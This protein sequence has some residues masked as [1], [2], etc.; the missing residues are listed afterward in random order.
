MESNQ[1]LI[2]S[3]WVLPLAL[4]ALLLPIAIMEYQ[5]LQDTGGTFCYGLDDPFIHLSIGKNLA[6][7]GV[8]GTTPHEFSSASSSIIYPILIAGTIKLIGTSTIIPFLLNLA[9]AVILLITVRNWL[10]EQDIPPAYQL[11]I[12]LALIYFTPLPITVMIGMEHTFQLLFCFLFIISFSYSL[13]D[14]PV[15]GGKDGRLPWKVY[16]WAGLM[17]AT[18]Y[19]SG[20]LIAAALM[21]LLFH[22]RIWT[23]LCL[24]FFSFLPVLLF[25]FYSLYNGAYFLPNSVLLKSRAPH[26]AFNELYYFFTTQLYERLSLAQGPH[27]YNS[28]SVQRL[29]LILPLMYFIFN[30][31]VRKQ[32][33]YRYIIFLLTTGFVAQLAVANIDRSSRYEAYLIGCAVVFILFLALKYGKEIWNGWSQMAKGISIFLACIMCY[34]LVFRSGRAFGDIELASVNIFQQ[35]YQMGSFFHKYYNND[36]IALNDIGAVSYL[37]EG[38]KL[39]LIGLSSYEITKARLNNYYTPQVVSQAV[40]KDSVKVAVVFDVWFPQQFFAGW[41]PVG[42]WTIQNNIICLSNTVTFYAVD[43]TFRQGLQRNLHG[44]ERFLPKDVKAAYY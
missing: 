32:P 15:A 24:A 36:G 29:I 18:R 2:P 3:K 12:L 34:P 21:L 13:A 11:L 8:W 10:V 39:D 19:E 23:A 30:N 28:V 35:Q 20:I 4:L 42:T 5:I 6:N 37:T 16:L 33:A 7:H 9:A 31:Q 14:P 22:K 38:K 27:I 1:P 44:Y 40:K 41:I 26:L 43:T 17:T 25:G